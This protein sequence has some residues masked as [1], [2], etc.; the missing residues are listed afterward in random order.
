MPSFQSFSQFVFPAC[1]FFSLQH[2]FFSF[3]GSLMLPVVLVVVLASVMGGNGQNLAEALGDALASCLVLALDLGLRL[4]RTLFF[5][6]I[7]LLS[8]LVRIA[9][10]WRANRNV[11]LKTG[12]GPEYG[13]PLGEERTNGGP[14]NGD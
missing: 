12:S 5:G 7:C 11:T 14:K 3:I 8:A 10:S 9:V 4:G 6:L 13:P 1:D 2:S